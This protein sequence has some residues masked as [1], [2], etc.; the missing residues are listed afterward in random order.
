MSQ[1]FGASAGAR[2]TL[3]A[4]AS[5]RGLGSVHFGANVSPKCTETPAEV[6]RARLIQSNDKYGIRKRR[7]PSTVMDFGRPTPEIHHSCPAR[8]FADDS[9]S[10]QWPTPRRGA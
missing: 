3:T 8:A 1:Q 9:P 7:A 5:T 4:V 6:P 2:R 10:I